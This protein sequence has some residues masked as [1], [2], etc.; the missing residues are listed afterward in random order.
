MYIV[1]AL[2]FSTI[3]LLLSVYSIGYCIQD[4]FEESDTYYEILEGKADEPC[5]W[6]F[7]LR[8]F[9]SWMSFSIHIAGI[10]GMKY[11][12]PKFMWPW[13]CSFTIASIVVVSL[14]L[15]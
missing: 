3:G 14:L 8:F 2:L 13:I 6:K 7:W 1:I 11:R 15:L 10:Y 5:Y 12:K 4:L 9:A